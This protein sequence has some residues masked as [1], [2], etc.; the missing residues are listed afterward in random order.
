MLRHIGALIAAFISVASQG[1]VTALDRSNDAGN[2]WLFVVDDLHINFADTGRVRTFLRLAASELLRDGDL[3]ELRTTGP[4]ASTP[5]TRDL[6]VFLTGIKATTGHGLQPLDILGASS[7]KP[8]S[9]EVVSRANTAL[10]AAYDG[11]IAFAMAD[12][13][14]K[15]IVYISAG[16]DVDASGLADRVGA[17][18]QRARED[19]ITIFAIDARGFESMPLPDSRV[20]AAAWRRYVTATQRSLT[21][22]AE[23]AGGFVIEKGN[24]PV[25][26]LK[27]IAL[28]LQ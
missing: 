1:G 20:D 23:Q 10:D 14:R 21:M 16:Y 2:A 26:D 3:V 27:R 5:P 19:D 7:A 18:A 15:A 17:F 13:R 4:S 28:M 11:L 24:A 9:G 25:N 8:A 6:N 12:G 22:M